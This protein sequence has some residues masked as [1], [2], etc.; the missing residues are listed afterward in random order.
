MTSLYE[1][2]GGTEGITAIADDLVNNH[3]ANPRIAPRY[4]A[5]DIAKVKHAAATFFITRTRRIRRPGHAQGTS[6][7]EYRCRRVHR[8]AR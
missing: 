5:S 8:R 1:R 4:T 7:Y 2:L 3:V 6:G